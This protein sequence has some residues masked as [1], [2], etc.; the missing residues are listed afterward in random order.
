MAR[1]TLESVLL[2]GRD[3]CLR[4]RNENVL[5]GWETKE[6][7]RRKEEVAQAV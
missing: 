7:Q 3:N 1:V 5:E 4:K 6:V 2:T